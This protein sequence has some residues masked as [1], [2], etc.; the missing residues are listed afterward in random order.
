MT[1]YERLMTTLNGKPVDRVPVCF[2]EIDG[3]SQN[4]DDHDPF[5]IFS[6]PSWKPLIDLAKEK[7]DRIVLRGVPFI[8]GSQ[9]AFMEKDGILKRESYLE[10]DS[11]YTR[12]SIN[13]GGKVL[14]SLARRDKDINT[15]WTIE[16]LLKNSDDLK[17]WLQLPEYAFDCVPDTS[18]V[19]DAEKKIGDSGIVGI[20][21]G[22]PLVMVASLFDMAEYTIT[23]MTEPELFHK[24]LD[25]AAAA[26]YRKTE[27]VA[28]AL[29]GRLWRICGPE[30]ASPPYLPPALFR[31]YVTAYVKPMVEIIHKYGG[32]ARV[33]SHGRLK[34]ILDMIVETGCMALDP[35][36]PPQ[37]GDVEL[38]YVRKKY[39]RQLVLFGN[40][41]ASDLENLPTPRFEEKIMKAL[42]EG[43]QGEG[44]GFVLM[45]SACPYGRVLPDLAL[46]NYEKMIECAEQAGI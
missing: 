33:H 20:D 39:G 7:S 5:N 30:Y 4:P 43:T 16:H 28:K 6:H 32:Y 19:L 3:L 37:Q 26:L 35:I 24:A 9:E 12:T 36:E 17:L 34:D 8:G 2:Y 27:A 14:T 18:V 1:R 44:R 40:L 46:R 38:E 22:D 23:A 25:K 29:P 42:R 15:T 21:T 13:I 11:R 10:D 31:E 45:P 41:E